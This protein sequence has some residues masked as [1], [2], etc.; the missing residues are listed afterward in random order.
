VLLVRSSKAFAGSDGFSPGAVVFLRWPGSLSRQVFHKIT[1]PS[2]LGC[3]DLPIEDLQHRI[4]QLELSIDLSTDWFEI[5][6][7]VAELDQLKEQLA[8]ARRDAA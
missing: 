3:F 4:D 6:W 1:G 2:S 5:Q 7:L 8:F